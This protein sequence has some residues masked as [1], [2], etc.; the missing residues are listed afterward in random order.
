MDSYKRGTSVAKR[1]ITQKNEKPHR[2]VFAA[3][4]VVWAKDSEDA[5]LQFQHSSLTQAEFRELINV[6]EVNLE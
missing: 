1:K 3:E 4:I 2:V 5:V 6:E